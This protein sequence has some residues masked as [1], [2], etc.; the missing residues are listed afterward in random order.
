VLAQV[1]GETCVSLYL[2]RLPSVAVQ[3]QSH[4]FQGP[5]QGSLS[6]LKE[7][8]T[9]R[10]RLPVR[11]AV[12]SSRRRRA[13]MSR[14]G[15]GPKTAARKAGPVDSF[16]TIRPMGW[17]CSPLRAQREH[18][19]FQ[20]AKAAGRGRGPIPSD[21]ADSGDDFAARLPYVLAAGERERSAGPCSPIFPQSG[22]K[23]RACMRMRRR[24]RGGHRSCPGATRQPAES[25]RRE[26]CCS[27]MSGSRAGRPRRAGRTEHAADSSSCRSAR[28]DVP[29]GQNTYPGLAD[30]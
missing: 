8:G 30:K 17:R 25:G 1:K 5:R 18:C 23:F 12:R 14:T 3:G 7:A 2:R 9:A 22:C 19:A 29:F 4:R 27:N 20:F 15:Q 6:Q 16:W 13:P 21:A 28:V 11:R 10:L 24:Q 26:V